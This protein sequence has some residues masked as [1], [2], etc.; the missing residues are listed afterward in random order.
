MVVKEEPIGGAT[1]RQ[2]HGIYWM[3]IKREDSEDNYRRDDY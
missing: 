3:K 1:S 2:T